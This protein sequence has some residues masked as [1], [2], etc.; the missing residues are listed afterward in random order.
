MGTLCASQRDASAL[1]PL[2][3]HVCVFECVGHWCGLAMQTRPTTSKLRVEPGGTRRGLCAWLAAPRWASGE[4]SVRL[5]STAASPV[6]QRVHCVTT[7]QSFVQTT[8]AAVDRGPSKSRAPRYDHCST[9]VTG[10]QC[11]GCNTSRT[12]GCAA[13]V[14]LG[15]GQ[16]AA[17]VCARWVVRVCVCVCVCVC[18]R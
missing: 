10:A 4:I 9:G 1:A 5:P 14:T 13:L 17:V 2:A 7:D 8:G 6:T 18:W 15:C 3:L 11:E 16:C 12:R